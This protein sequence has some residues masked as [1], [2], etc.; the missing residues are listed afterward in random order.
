MGLS[1]FRKYGV[2]IKFQDNSSEIK[3]MLQEAIKKGLEECGKLAKK[4]A[5][6]ELR[7]PKAHKNG[8]VRPNI[9]TGD[10]VDS[11]D[12]DVY[13]NELYVG[14]DI[15]YSIF[16]EFG[17]RRSWAYPYLTPAIKNHKEQYKNI[18][19][20]ALRKDA[21]YPFGAS[22]RIGNKD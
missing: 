19:K 12:Y 22:V 21:N 6:Q 4:Y 11:I 13:N 1:T 10:L 9:I 18:L 15:F 20:R 14:S 2:E 7:K 5:Q 3:K 16:V 17:T 8:E